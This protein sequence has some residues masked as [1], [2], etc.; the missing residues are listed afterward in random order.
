MSSLNKIILIGELRSEPDIKATNSGDAVCNFVLGVQR[1]AR[2]ENA[3]PGSDD[4]KVV[5]WREKAELMKHVV[6][7]QTV[8]VEGRIHTRSYDNNEGQRVYV[9]EVEARDIRP[10]G[11]ASQPARLDVQKPKKKPVLEAMETTGSEPSFDFSDDEK[12]LASQ[13]SKNP[14]FE[15]DDIPF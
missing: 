7:G 15:A 6:E 8:L 9:T 13:G 14:Q 5:A 4:I 2:V 3:N 1:P 11:S 12:V 10:M